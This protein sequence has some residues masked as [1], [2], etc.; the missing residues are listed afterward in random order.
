MQNAN[1]NAMLDTHSKIKE[2]PFYL[3]VRDADVKAKKK[4]LFRKK[5]HKVQTVKKRYAPF[6][7]PQM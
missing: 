7:T 4:T 2:R 3:P 6:P 1:A 5:V